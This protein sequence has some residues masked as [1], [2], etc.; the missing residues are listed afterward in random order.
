MIITFKNPQIHV[1][2]TNDV[3]IVGKLG[4]ICAKRL[5]R[6]LDDLRAAKSLSELRSAP[7]G[8]KMTSEKKG[9]FSCDLDHQH[10][11]VFEAHKKPLPTTSD[12]ECNWFA[13]DGIAIVDI[14]K[15]N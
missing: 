12:G 11:L 2:I 8:Y 9:Q 1:I 14:I 5:K 4:A 15:H 7:G 3:R 10:C 6:R 13:I